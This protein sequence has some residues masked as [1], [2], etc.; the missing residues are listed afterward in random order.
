MGRDISMEICVSLRL[1]P[2]LHLRSG[3]IYCAADFYLLFA[4]RPFFPPSG[5]F[6]SGDKG[7]SYKRKGPPQTLLTF[8]FTRT[9][10]SAVRSTCFPTATECCYL[11]K[12]FPLSRE[13]GV[14]CWN[15]QRDPIFYRILERS[16]NRTLD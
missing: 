7:I 12:H 3:G 15:K 14:Y 16:I 13:R 6:S 5:P 2:W 4:V 8:P 10:T 11:L 1:L 9:W